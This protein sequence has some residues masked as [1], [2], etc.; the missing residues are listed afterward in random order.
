MDRLIDK[1]SQEYELG[2]HQIIVCP[3]CSKPI[4]LY[5]LEILCSHCGLTK[6]LEDTGSHFLKEGVRNFLSI[7]CCGET[8]YARNVEHLDLL[9]VFVKTEIEEE[10]PNHV[11]SFAN[12]LPQWIK[13][14]KNRSAILKC[15]SKL[16]MSL[17]QQGYQPMTLE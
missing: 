17:E 8:L 15:I 5:A 7:R 3:C 14:Q 12:R 16:R 1:D 9:E 13:N 11:R 6:T 10:L 2:A 4:D